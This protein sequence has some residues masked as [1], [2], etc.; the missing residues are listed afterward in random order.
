MSAVKCE[1][2]N[3]NKPAKM[4]C[5][6]CLK[7]GI[8]SFFC[9][10]ACFKSSWKNHR[11]IHILATGE[12]KKSG[13]V[14]LYPNY[15]YSGKLRPWPQTPKRPV[16]ESIKRPD[17]ANHPEGRSLSEEKMRGENDGFKI[18]PVA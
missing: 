6:T 18:L 1:T 2:V 8:E 9:D 4:K 17:Y 7:I 5:P 13:V 12:D 3:C 16:P 11:I 15:T 10:Q 14:N